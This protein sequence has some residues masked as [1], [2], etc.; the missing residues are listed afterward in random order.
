M[1]FD[2][3][4]ARRYCL[5]SYLEV[6]GL[7]VDGDVLILLLILHVGTHDAVENLFPALDEFGRFL[8]QGPVTVLKRDTVTYST[9]TAR[10]LFERRP[11]QGHTRCGT[12]ATL[13]AADRRLVAALS[14][15]SAH[16]E[17][18]YRL[19]RSTSGTMRE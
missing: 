6:L 5:R 11:N 19:K 3:T 7:G 12:G 1:P 14:C 17:G 16:A 4:V 2:Q 10:P 15:K 13:L 9:P 18:Y 8:G